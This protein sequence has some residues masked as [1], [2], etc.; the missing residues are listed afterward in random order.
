MSRSPV[1]PR[2]RRFG[3]E[4]EE[5]TGKG[6]LKGRM[7]TTE[8]REEERG[9]SLSKRG[10]VCTQ[11]PPMEAEL[12]SGTRPVRDIVRWALQEAVG[13]FRLQVRRC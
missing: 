11:R 7:I 13:T 4:E 5:E 9:C 12:V 2:R 6:E 10:V 8:E 1:A 3:R